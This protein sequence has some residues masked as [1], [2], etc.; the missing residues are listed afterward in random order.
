MK[1]E[2]HL[3]NI[4]MLGNITKNSSTLLNTKLLHNCTSV[5]NLFYYTIS[6][7]DWDEILL[8]LITF[9][10]KN[11]YYLRPQMALTKS[12]TDLYTLFRKRFE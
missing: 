2:V 10:K 11:S 9:S 5:P 3:G 4:P 8:S 1:E 7:L 6:N 12:K